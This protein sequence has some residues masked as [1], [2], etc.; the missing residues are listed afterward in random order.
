V[1]ELV[2]TARD[3]G[4]AFWRVSDADTT[5]YVLGVPS[6]APKGAAW[7]RATLERRLE[8]ANAVILPFN[9][10][11]V[12]A[13]GVPGAAFNLLRLR[14]ST[15]YEEKLPPDLKARFIAARTAMGKE[16]GDYRTGNGVAA[17]LLLVSNYRDH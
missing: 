12:N 7:D 1:E 5:V 14:S 2:V 3:P 4:P 10:I 9:E 13:L 8:G 16:A 17:G 15:P 6:V 11:K